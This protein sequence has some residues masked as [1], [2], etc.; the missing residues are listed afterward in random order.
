MEPFQ[1]VS[2]DQQKV[3]VVTYDSDE[4]FNVMF[5]ICS[6]DCFI[7]PSNLFLS[8]Y[9]YITCLSVVVYSQLNNSIMSQV[10][11]IE[12]PGCDTVKLNST[13]PLIIHFPVNNYTNHTNVSIAYLFK[14]SQNAQN[15]LLICQF[16]FSVDIHRQATYIPVNTMMNKVSWN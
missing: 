16:C 9:S 6:S 11:R 5:F 7:R 8:P 12:V 3:A 4:Q 10:I 2:E 13:N 15:I 1:N 14:F